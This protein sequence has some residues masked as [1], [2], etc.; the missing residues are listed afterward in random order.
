MRLGVPEVQGVE[1]MNKHQIWLAAMSAMIP[2]HAPM[3]RPCAKGKNRKWKTQDC[4]EVKR[5]KR[6]GRGG[7]G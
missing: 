4:G 1:V 2:L 6:A 7:Q 3:Q 5:R